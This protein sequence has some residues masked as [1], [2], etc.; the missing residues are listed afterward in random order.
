M[1]VKLI[2]KDE[3]CDLEQS[4]FFGEILL[5][6]KWLL[7]DEFSPDELFLCQINLDDL[8]SAVGKTLLP[9]HGMLYFFIDY[10]KKPQAVVRYY[11]GEADAYTSFNEDWEGDYDVVTEWAIDFS[12]FLDKSSFRLEKGENLKD[13]N[14][15]L[16]RENFTAMLVKDENVEN[17]EIAILKYV[18]DASDIDFLSG[19]KKT[20]YFIMKES[21]LKE[22]DFSSVILKL[23]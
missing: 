4:K 10:A 14:D 3:D 5:P 6:E 11:D 19:T 13:E 22:F 15:F 17:G 23:V 16:K 12:S 20:L 9:D 8:A 7:E 1:S 18:P 2:I 21:A